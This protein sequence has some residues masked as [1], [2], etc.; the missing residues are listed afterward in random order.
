MAFIRS[1]LGPVTGKVGELVMSDTKDGNVVRVY[2][3]KVSNPRTVN[4]IL[5]RAQLKPAQLFYGKLVEILDHSFAQSA[6]PSYRDFMSAALKSGTYPYMPK[7]I[8]EAWPGVYDMT[9][10]SLASISREL[11]E[12]AMYTYLFVPTSVSTITGRILIENNSDM[13][14]DGD[15]LTI[16]ACGRD[17]NDNT[18]WASTR[19]NVAND[20]RQINALLHNDGEVYVSVPD[21]EGV[22]SQMEAVEGACIIRSTMKGDSYVYSKE[23]FHVSS[24]DWYIS[25]RSSRLYDWMLKSY[26]AA[27][28]SNM[29]RGGQKYLQQLVGVQP[30]DGVLPPPEVVNAVEVVLKNG[31][32]IN[33]YSIARNDGNYVLAKQTTALATAILVDEDGNNIKNGNNDVKYGDISEQS[34]KAFAGCWYVETYSE[35]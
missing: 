29:Y 9:K 6:L 3:P 28:V 23:K 33:I 10:G 8:N 35:P 14:K 21:L 17:A 26:G 13:I 22:F 20:D 31:A 4:Q 16:I 1:I 34:L 7:T 24:T 12:G 15:Q 25:Y 2:Q 19:L 5:R 18:R 30:N 11:I 27:A 32:S